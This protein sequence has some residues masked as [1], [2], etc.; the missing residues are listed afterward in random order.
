MKYLKIKLVIM[1]FTLLVYNICYAQQDSVKIKGLENRI[2]KAEGF[3]TNTE[4]AL[5]NKFIALENKINDDYSLL[6]ILAWSGIGLTFFSL[7]GLW[8]KGKRHIEEKLKEKFDKIITQQE[9]NILELIDKHDIE[10][11][12]LKTKKI[13][14]LTAKNGDDTFVRKFFK[15][16][17]FQIDNVNYEKVDSYKAFD[18][19]DLI[20]INNEDIT[21]DETLIQ[22]YFEK[23]KKNVVLFFFGNRFTK[24][25]NVL[26]RMSFAN[27]RTQIY[28]NILNLLKY[29]EVLK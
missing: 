9:G 14:V 6:K 7:L 23:S 5:D 24:G 8:W 3:Q 12:I 15:I 28:G 21:F 2:E 27:S 13:L 19:F 29:Q 20:F 16:M 25:E 17:G 11:Q 1:I 22:E 4:K 26:S 18:N 10:N